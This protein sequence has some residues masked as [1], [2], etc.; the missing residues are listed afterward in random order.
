M[1]DPADPAFD[2]DDVPVAAGRLPAVEAI[3][4]LVREAWERYRGNDEGEN[5]QHYPALAA[6]PRGLFGICVV[7]TGGAAHAAGDV[8]HP[9]TIMSVAKPFV[10]AL[11]CEAIGPERARGATGVNATGAKR[12]CGHNAPVAFETFHAHLEFGTVFDGSATA[13]TSQRDR[14]SRASHVGR[15]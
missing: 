3:G 7:G 13:W 4:A 12:R 1:T 6:A 2:D 5:A 9:F 8:D 11:V 14:C 10:F 15:I